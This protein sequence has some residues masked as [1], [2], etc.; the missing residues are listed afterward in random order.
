MPRHSVTV[1]AYH[2]DHSI[3]PP[4]TCTWASE[5]CPTK[6]YATELGKRHRT[7]QHSAQPSEAT[8]TVLPGVLR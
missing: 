1:T 6:G 8:Q 7:Q 4:C 5:K 2:T 3:C